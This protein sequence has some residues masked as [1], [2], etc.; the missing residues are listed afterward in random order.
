MYK[1]I[2]KSLPGLSSTISNLNIASKNLP[3]TLSTS[4]NPRKET[5]SPI[6]MWVNANE[7]QSYYNDKNSNNQDLLDSRPI[8]PNNADD[9][10][11][12]DDF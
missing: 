9:I 12:C 4:Y 10:F 2:S 6:Q 7:S 3:P 5:L 1:F 8:S 11:Q